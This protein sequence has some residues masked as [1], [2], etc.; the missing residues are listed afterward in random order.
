VATDAAKRNAA[1]NAGP[2]TRVLFG[3]EGRIASSVYGTVLV[4]ATLT[5]ASAE[6]GHPWRLIGIVASGVFVVWLA[7]LYAH[8]L[9]ESIELGRRVTRHDVERI[10]HRELGILLAAALPLG[11]LLLG[12]VGVLRE[13]TAVWLALATALFALAV[14]G[15][16]YATVEALSRSA[17]VAVVAANVALGLLVVVLKAF[18][19][20]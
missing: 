2:V 1:E 14:A 6:R 16:H 12:A 20:H 3:V 18:V 8:S 7:H 19:I 17:T 5:A 11:A 10:A 13:T 15:L 4:M 9:S